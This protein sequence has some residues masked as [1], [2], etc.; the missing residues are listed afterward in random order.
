MVFRFEAVRGST[1]KK[2]FELSDANYFIWRTGGSGLVMSRLFRD[3]PG[4]TELEHFP[5]GYTNLWVMLRVGLWLN[6]KRVGSWP[7][8]EAAGGFSDKGRFYAFDATQKPSHWR[9]LEDGQSYYGFATEAEAAAWCDGQ[10]GSPLILA[11]LIE[12]VFWH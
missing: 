7:L 8:D 6:G 11:Q 4:M 1:S 9:H 3:R 2:P 5:M 12:D 10:V